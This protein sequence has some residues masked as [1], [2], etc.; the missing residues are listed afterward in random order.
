MTVEKNKKIE[1]ITGERII[2]YIDS[3]CPYAEDVKEEILNKG[4]DCSCDTCPPEFKDICRVR[5]IGS[6]A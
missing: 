2:A 4:I 3:H 1:E 5:Y 6:L